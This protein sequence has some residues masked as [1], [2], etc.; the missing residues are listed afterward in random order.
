VSTKRNKEIKEEIVEK[1]KEEIKREKPSICSS[2][3]QRVGIDI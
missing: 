2:F 1:L 3:P